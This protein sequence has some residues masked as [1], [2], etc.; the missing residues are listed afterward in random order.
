VNLRENTQMTSFELSVDS[1][2]I[3]QTRERIATFGRMLFDRF[4]TDA[5]GGNVSVRVGDLVCLSPRYSG[6]KRQWRLQPDDV[7]VVDLH[8]TKLAGAGDLSRASKVHLRRYNEYP[9]GASVVHAHPKHV[10]VFCAARRPIPPVLEATMKFGT[11]NVTEFAPAHSADLALHVADGLRG[12]ESRIRKQAA[13]VLAPWHGIFC[14]GKDLDAAF[15]AVERIDN[16]A[17]I[18]LESRALL[19]PA[20]FDAEIAALHEAMAGH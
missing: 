8:G 11:I 14:I 2:E 19:S 1:K 5:A 12:Q 13:A 16:N 9:D 18:I 15:D 6:Q 7:L 3:Q 20:D 10:L 4:L 17:R